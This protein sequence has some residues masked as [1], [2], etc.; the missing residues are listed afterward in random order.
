MTTQCVVRADE[1]PSRSETNVAKRQKGLG[2]S[3]TIDPYTDTEI[4]R[5]GFHA[6]VFRKI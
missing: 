1:G 6:W 2:V 5:S 4:L 3:R